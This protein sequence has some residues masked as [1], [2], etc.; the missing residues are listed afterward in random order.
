MVLTSEGRRRLWTGANQKEP[1][2][3][4]SSL[5]YGPKQRP[6]IL[7]RPRVSTNNLLIIYHFQQR[8]G[9]AKFSFV[10]GLGSTLLLLLRTRPVNPFLDSSGPVDPTVSCSWCTYP[11]DVSRRP[12]GTPLRCPGEKTELTSGG[13]E[14]LYFPEPVRQGP[15]DRCRG[16]RGQEWR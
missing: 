7:S 10:G 13:S 14:V 11:T 8:R 9:S 16:R 5:R 1:P 6:C 2:T 15:V 12:P 3:S 4:K